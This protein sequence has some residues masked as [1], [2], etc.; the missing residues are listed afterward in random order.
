MHWDYQ[1]GWGGWLAS[2][3]MMLVFWGGVAAVIVL[4]LLRPTTARTN[5]AER[6]L[7]ARFA[8][9]EIDEDEYRQRWQVLH[10]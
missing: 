8:R 4:L 5:D 9:G 3:A 10:R 6:I 1:Y 2:M 7:A